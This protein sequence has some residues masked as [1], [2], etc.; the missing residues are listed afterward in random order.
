MGSAKIN[1]QLATAAK[2]LAQGNPT[3]AHTDAQ[4][5]LQVYVYV[6]DTMPETLDRLSQAGL[7]GPQASAEMGLVQGWVAPQD[8]DGLAALPCVKTISFPRYAS[9][10]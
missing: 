5:R 1:P 10:R 9:P 7:A 3:T 4:G 6:T 2:A 8:L